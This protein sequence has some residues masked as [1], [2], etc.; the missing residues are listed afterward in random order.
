MATPSRTGS[1]RT[2]RYDWRD[3]RRAARHV[4]TISSAPLLLLCVAVCVLWLRSYRAPA[5]SA[6]AADSISFTRSEPLY[7]VIA[8]PGRLT[9]CRQV[10]ANWD[11]PLRGFNAAGIEFGGSWGEDGSI[12]W[13]LRM[14]CWMLAAVT[15]LPLPLAAWGVVRR[16]RVRRSARLGLCRHCGYD[17]RASPERC[18][19]CGTPGARDRAA[20]PSMTPVR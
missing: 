4:L 16:R 7:W 2:A 1:L 20:G 14:P 5:N 17:L 8:E 15:A 18:P 9:L 10:G 6:A 3:M 11:F 19:E 12:L 13:N